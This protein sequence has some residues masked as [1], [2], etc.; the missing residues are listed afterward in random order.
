MLSAYDQD[1]H[2]W[3]TEQAGLVRSGRLTQLDQEN[4]AEELEGLARRDRREI[5]SRLGVLLMHLLKWVYQPKA[6][7]NSWKAMI[8]EQRQ[9]IFKLVEE[10]PSLNS[11]PEQVLDKE[12]ALARDRAAAETGLS[13]ETFPRWRPFSIEQVL[14]SEYLP[15]EPGGERLF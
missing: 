14:D 2:A 5:A 3:A 8:V 4:V 13:V 15:D 9:S 7:S 10:S 6:R 11:Y 1:F 12:Y